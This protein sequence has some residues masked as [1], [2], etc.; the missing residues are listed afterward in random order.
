[1]STSRVVYI[2]PPNAP[3]SKES[4]IKNIEHYEV[5]SEEIRSETFHNWPVEFIGKNYL[6]ATG[7]YY[8]GFKDVVCCAFCKVE[9]QEWEPEDCPFKEHKRWS[10]TCGFISKLFIGVN[11]LLLTMKK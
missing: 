11:L 10:P 4:G 2:P 6:A 5:K 8:T 9:L 3:P 7:F 1:M